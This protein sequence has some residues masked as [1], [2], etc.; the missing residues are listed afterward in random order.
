MYYVIGCSSDLAAYLSLAV[1]PYTVLLHPSHLSL[2]VVGGFLLQSVSN[3]FLAILIN[4]YPSLLSRS[5]LTL[6][7]LASVQD[8]LADFFSFNNPVFFLT[9]ILPH[10]G[11]LALC[12]GSL[13]DN[14]NS[15]NL[16]NQ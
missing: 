1:I 8:T 13:F 10:L 6:G 7:I 12:D 3:I 16:I 15:T 14:S 2:T 5:C 9:Y 11:I 4:V